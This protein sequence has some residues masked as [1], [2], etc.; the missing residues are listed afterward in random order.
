MGS[1]IAIT[2]AIIIFTL[3]P[4]A[5]AQ[6]Y[7]RH[8]CTPTGRGSCNFG[9]EWSPYSTAVY[10]YD[11]N[12]QLIGWSSVV[13]QYNHEVTTEGILPYPVIVN[14]PMSEKANF[15]YAN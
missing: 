13:E 14:N 11:L 1:L 7:G 4:D 9:I 6:A 10:L 2:T 8:Y 12:C 15:S 3:I 5:I